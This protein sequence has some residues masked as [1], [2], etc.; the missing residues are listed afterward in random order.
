MSG[1]F[2]SLNLV[3]TKSADGGTV[4][5]KVVNPAAIPTRVY[6]TLPGGTTI[7]NATVQ[8]VTAASLTTQNSLANPNAVQAVAGSAMVAGTT[9]DVT[10]P[11]Y[12]A[13]VVSIDIQ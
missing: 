2:G 10:L 5:V 7:N 4:V 6:F 1:D 12:S 11:A 9:V 13:S 3:A 8:H